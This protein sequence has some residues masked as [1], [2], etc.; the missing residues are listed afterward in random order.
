MNLIITP[1]LSEKAYAKVSAENIYVFNVPAKVSKI[2]IKQAVESLYSVTVESVN[3]LNTIGKTKRTV[4]KGGRQTKGKRADYRKAYI[5]V[6]KGQTIPVF[7]TTEDSKG[8]K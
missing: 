4:R 1:R 2:A 8:D 6:T 7:A 3:V 5:K